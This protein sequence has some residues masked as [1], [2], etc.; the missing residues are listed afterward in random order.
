MNIVMVGS[1]EYL[2][3]I[4]ALDRELLSRLREP[5]QVVC[6]PTAAGT[7]GKERIAYWSNL[8]VQHFSRL[9]AEVEALPV[10]NPQ[11]ANDPVLA[12]RVAAANFI[13]LSGGKPAYLHHCLENSLVWTAIQQVLA[14]GG[15]LAGCSAGAMVLG[16]KFLGFPGLKSGFNLAPGMVIIPHY[17]EISAAMLAGLRLLIGNHLTLVGVEANT[18]LVKNEEGYEVLGLGGVTVWNNHH[19][20]RFEQGGRPV[21]D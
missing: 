17:D 1:G 13:Y 3:P 5:P 8:G 6:L 20:I 14:R 7:E 19:A 12:E 11:S 21:L 2:E 4:S 16:E 18:A 10:I 9:G 15:I